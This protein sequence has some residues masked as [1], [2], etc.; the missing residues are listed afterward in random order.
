MSQSFTDKTISGVNWNLLSTYG[1]A[2]INT[3]VGIVLARLL[4]PQDF[5]LIG[6]VYIFTGLADLFA[7]LGMGQSVIRIKNLNDNYIRVA[8]TLTITA[9]VLI[10]LIFYFSAPL[11]ADFYNEPKIIPIIKVLS[12]LFLIKAV[13]TVSY[14]Q[15]Q[16]NL[17]FK[18]L[19]VVS[20]TNSF[21]YGVTSSVL[22]I[23]GFGVWSLVYGS[24]AAAIINGFLILR[25]S[26]A[27]LKP[28]LKKNEFKELAGFGS[29]VSL[30]NILL[31][32]SSNVDYLIIG[33]F[34]NPYALGLYTR[35]FNLMTESISRISGG[36]YNVLFPA[37]S[38]AQNEKQKLRIAY[39]RTIKTLSYFI[40]PVLAVMIIN[41]DYI[42]KGLYGVKWAGAVPVFRILAFGGILRA[43]LPYS[44]AIAHATGRV[45]AEVFQQ[46]VYFLIL[47]GVAWYTI[48]FGIEGVAFA[49]VAALI[50]MFFAQSWLALKIIE[51]SWKEFL[52][53]LI[54]A[55][56][57]LIVMVC[58]NMIL[59]FLIEKFFFEMKAEI[60]LIIMLILNAAA[61]LSV[62]V[63]LPSSIKGD[64]F[65]WL[66]E[67]YKKYLPSFFL[68]F[69][70]SF[71]QSGKKI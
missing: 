60:K 59:V 10:Y 63:F 32:G 29:G 49:V 61:F 57:N 36:I 35:A 65:D 11:I 6:M 69:Y 38:A 23:M 1:N 62:I 20:I 55:L 70:F 64:T 17:D 67:K 42:I 3:I 16:K 50:W 33:K 21:T 25:K 27:N 8:T 58:I 43:T 13:A 41:A 30:S 26:P 5:G 53:S 51:S 68:R 7:T 44:G 46:L 40:F 15:L 22:A 14:S 48:R 12:F 34:I 31:Y 45:Y 39:L 54:P 24:L 2:V 71:N 4:T 56:G 28:L 19:M 18:T 66:I 47:G 52:Y 37:F 9:S